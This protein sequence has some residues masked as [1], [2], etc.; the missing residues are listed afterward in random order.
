[1]RPF[2]R[3]VAPTSIR[4]RAR[5]AAALS[6]LGLAWL[7]I[8][9]AAHALQTT[10][11]SPTGLLGPEGASATV[12]VTYS[13]DPPGAPNFLNVSVRQSSGK[14]LTQYGG[15]VVAGLV[16]DSAVHTVL[17]T[18]GPPLQNVFPLKQGEAAVTALLVVNSPTGPQT[19]TSVGPEVVRLRR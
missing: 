3:Q 10:A 18:A 2:V 14:R 17:V 1:V 4:R 9:P 6:A 12:T 7:A 19:V 15:S 11:V 13:C 16:C 5:R 8:P